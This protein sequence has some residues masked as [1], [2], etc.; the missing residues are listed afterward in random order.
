M[1]ECVENASVI[2]CFLTQAYQNSENCRIELTYAKHNDLTSGSVK[3]LV[4]ELEQNKTLTQ[5]HLHTN[6]LDD[7]SV[8]YLAQLLT[9]K[10]T[11]LICLGLDEIDLTDKGA[12]IVFNA[13][14]TNSSLKTLYLT[15]NKSITDASIDSFIQML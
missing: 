7:K 10:N 1:G 8:Q 2:I 6:H 14:R 3:M 11:T 13:R 5:L 4:D 12:Q 15:N 9:G